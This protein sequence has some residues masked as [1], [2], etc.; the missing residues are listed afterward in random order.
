[1]QNRQDRQHSTGRGKRFAVAI[2]AGVL[3]AAGFHGTAFAW[4]PAKPVEIVVPFSAGGASDQMAR[5]I[6][7]IIAKHQLMK[8][9]VIVVNK[10]G[11]SGA[12]GLM[13]TKASR[14]N[15]HKLLVTS[16]ALYT[17][18]MASNLPFSWRDLTPVAMVA[19][20][21][22]VLWTNASAPYKTVTEFVDSAKKSDGK[23]RMG[24]TSSKREDQI[25]T[26]LIQK[27]T[28]TKFI[29]IP[30]KGGGE[31]ATQ[32]S[33]QHIDANV[34]NPS[35]SIAQWRAGEHRALC[36]FAPERMNYT[37]K[38]TQTQSWKDIPTCKEQGLDVQYQMLR[39]FM[40]PGGVTPDQQ[41]YYVDLMQ[42][43][44]ATPEWKEYLERN[45]LKGEFIAGK[46]LEDFLVK[47]ENSHREI[48]KEAGFMAA[49]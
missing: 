29:Y 16:S 48:L 31:A 18:P 4:E 35:E 39:V 40:L 28:G 30:Y 44:V 14:G 49:R 11:A 45:A 13:D 43:I 37:T 2:G 5:S 36:V 3:A 24:G 42:K 9:P 47:D 17:V 27:K 23:T 38:V 34:N 19:Q 8:Q 32:L 46:P 6:Q 12:E 10:A 33:G 25:I 7:S 22:F 41:K 21:E 26:T 20:D 15:P 1:M